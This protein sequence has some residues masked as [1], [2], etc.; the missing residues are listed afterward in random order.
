MA[1]HR[2]D[3]TVF[4]NVLGTRE[5][6]AADRGGDTVVTTTIDAHGRDAADEPRAPRPTR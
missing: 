2:F 3:P 1:R 6:G 4:H 5:P